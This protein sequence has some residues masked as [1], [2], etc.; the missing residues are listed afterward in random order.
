L[1]FKKANALREIGLK[2]LPTL[3]KNKKLTHELTQ[4]DKKVK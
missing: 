2:K 1:D 4:K 3:K